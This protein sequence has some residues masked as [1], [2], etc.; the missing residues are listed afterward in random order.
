MAQENALSQKMRKLHKILDR[1]KYEGY[2]EGCKKLALDFDRKKL[3]AKMLN[4]INQ[5]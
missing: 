5:I 2:K 1:E 4:I 3:A